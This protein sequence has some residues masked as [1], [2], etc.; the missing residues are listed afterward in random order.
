MKLQTQAF[1]G[2]TELIDL[3]LPQMELRLAEQGLKLASQ[4]YTLD[5]PGVEVAST[6]NF[7]LTFQCVGLVPVQL[8]APVPAAPAEEVEPAIVKKT[9]KRVAELT[10]EKLEQKRAMWR[11][12][13]KQRRDQGKVPNRRKQ[14]IAT[15]ETAEVKETPEVV[16]PA[17][18]TF[19]AGTG[20][21]NHTG[22]SASAAA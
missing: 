8:P 11:E 20:N 22:A 13:A 7:T 19:R 14:Q 17:S 4:D 10:P 1:V 16:A 9:P 6:E 2:L 18:D 5:Y 15:V 12:K 21:G 3:A